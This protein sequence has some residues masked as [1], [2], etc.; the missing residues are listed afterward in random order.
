[1]AHIDVLAE[2]KKLSAAERLRVAEEALQLVRQELERTEL[3]RAR[4]ERTQRL[5]AAATALMSHTSPRRT[6]VLTV[7]GG[8]DG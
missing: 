7:E 1:M 5:T 2:L 8:E 6:E 3:L 4:S